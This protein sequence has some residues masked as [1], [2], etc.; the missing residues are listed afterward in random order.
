MARKG[1]AFFFSSECSTII[2]NNKNNNFRTHMSK[3]CLMNIDQ[4]TFRYTVCVKPVLCA[5]VLEKIE[6]GS[7]LFCLIILV[8]FFTCVGDLK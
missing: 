8:F 1:W 7:G 2:I 4:T 6:D 3:V 5:I